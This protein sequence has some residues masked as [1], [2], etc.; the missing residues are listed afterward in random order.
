MIVKTCSELKTQ[1]TLYEKPTSK[2]AKINCLFCSSFV[3]SSSFSYSLLFWRLIMRFPQRKSKRSIFVFERKKSLF[4]FF[5][6]YAAVGDHVIS[7]SSNMFW[8]TNEGSEQANNR[9]YWMSNMLQQ[10]QQQQQLR[11][12]NTKCCSHYIRGFGYKKKT[13]SSVKSNQKR[14][15]KKFVLLVIQ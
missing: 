14:I 13:P 1:K 5:L 9:Y 7:F 4:S 8:I 11:K 6:C 12:E 15:I 2:V 10:Q 3:L